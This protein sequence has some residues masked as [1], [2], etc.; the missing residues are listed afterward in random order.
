MAGIGV[1]SSTIGIAASQFLQRVDVQVAPHPVPTKLGQYLSD[2]AF[3][4]E[5]TQLIT[6]QGGPQAYAPLARNLDVSITRSSLD[7]QDQVSFLRKADPPVATLVLH[8][9]HLMALSSYIAAEEDPGMYRTYA[10]AHEIFAFGEAPG[11]ESQAHLYRAMWG[12]AQ[13]AEK[14]PDEAK[15]WSALA[16]RVDRAL[17][18][19]PKADRDTLLAFKGVVDAQ[20]SMDSLPIEEVARIL[21]ESSGLSVTPELV[22]EALQ[23]YLARKHREFP[24]D[25]Q[26]EFT[27][28]IETG[29][30]EDHL[31]TMMTIADTQ[32]EIHEYPLAIR[33]MSY[34]GLDRASG[35][36]VDKT[37]VLI[38]GAN[39]VAVKNAIKL[40]F[41]IGSRGPQLVSGAGVHT[42]EGWDSGDR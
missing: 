13:F 7:H 21:S 22:T 5:A 14:V 10:R 1:S 9:S 27:P 2:D 18:K 36:M 23:P 34:R 32:G 31:L 16:K 30:D 28:L 29:D 17:S 35:T 33:V 4:K 26:V 39:F 19:A 11:P 25:Q 38:R 6:A 3:R 37:S 24:A 8:A 15:A 20:L 42:S 41:T 12:C 40:G